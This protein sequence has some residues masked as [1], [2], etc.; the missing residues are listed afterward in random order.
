VR[1]IASVKA[2]NLEARRR[3]TWINHLVDRVNAELRVEKLEAGFAAAG[4]ALFGFDRVLVLYFGAR[5]ILAGDLTVGMLVAFVAFKDQFA[6]RVNA[7]VDTGLQFMMLSLHGERIADIALAE[8]EEPAR[9]GAARRAPGRPSTLELVDVGYRYAPTDPEVISGLS[10]R[11]RAGECIGIAGPSGAGK[12]TL[13]ALMAGL[14][15][16]TDGRIL[17]DGVPLEAVGTAAYRERV[18]CVLQ[19]D[20]LFTGSV[21]ENIAGFDPDARPE[22]IAEAARLAAIH[23]EILALPMG[24][25]TLVGDMGSALSGGQRQRLLLARALYRKPDILI[26]DEATSHLDEDNERAINA[27]VRRLDVTRIVVAHRASTLAATD[28][29]VS[30]GEIQRGAL[31]TAAE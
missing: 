29:V 27:A 24:Y 6:G 18:G 11:V 5:G 9:R 12:S 25:E 23:D 20:R 16:P 17:V 4:T 31:A 1:G 14:A 19:D 13:I 21:A 30:L 8:P 15:R 3:G 2:L 28:R 22:A 26:L 10:L 7:L